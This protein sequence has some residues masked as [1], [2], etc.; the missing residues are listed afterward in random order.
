MEGKE[1]GREGKEG[2]ENGK[3]GGR[4][5]KDREIRRVQEGERVREGVYYYYFRSI[6][7]QAALQVLY[8]CGTQSCFKDPEGIRPDTLKNAKSVEEL[9]VGDSERREEEADAHEEALMS[10]KEK[11]YYRAQNNQGIHSTKTW[12]TER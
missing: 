2:G 1:R 10:S 8:S 11:T 7:Q 9:K 12:K 4:E 6:S 5:G 3:N